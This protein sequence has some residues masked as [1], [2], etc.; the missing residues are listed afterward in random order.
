M[1]GDYLLSGGVVVNPHMAFPA[2]IRI[3]GTRV[4]EIDEDLRAR[5]NELV[6]NC[7]DHY[8]YPGLI[9]ARCC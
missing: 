9:N 8:I 2:D 1:I 7:T 4:I 3:Q 6:L 5:P